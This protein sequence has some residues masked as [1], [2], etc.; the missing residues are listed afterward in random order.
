MV[1]WLPL[2]RPLLTVL[3]QAGLTLL[4]AAGVPDGR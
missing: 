4:V 2:K 3:I 1:R